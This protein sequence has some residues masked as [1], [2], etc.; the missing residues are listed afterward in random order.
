MKTQRLYLDQS[1]LIEFEANII[2]SFSYKANYAV[3][4]DQTAFYPTSGGQMHDT[5]TINGIEVTDVIEDD[6]EIVHLL[7]SSITT[8]PSRCSINWPRRF[9][10]MQQHTGFHII[11]QSFLRVT[12]AETLSSHLGENISTIDVNLQALNEQQIREVEELAHQVIFEDR[13]VKAYF[14]DPKKIDE[15]RIRKMPFNKD[16]IRLVEI[17]DFDLDPCGGTHVSSTGQVGLIK[18]NR[19]EKIRGYLRCEFYAGWRAIR[20]YQKK[21]AIGLQLSN[22]LS[23]GE[24]DFVTSIKKI[25]NENRFLIK[26]KKILTEQNIAYEAQELVR[27]AH[28][29]G[30]KVITKLFENRDLNEVR[31]L[32]KQITQLGDVWV[33]FGLNGE[34]AHLIFACP[35]GIDYN[36]NELV[37]QVAHLIEGRGGGRPNFV[38]I[39]GPQKSSIDEALQSA[40]VIV[41]NNVL[42]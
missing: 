6:G 30:K 37:D 18:I 20:D 33:L 31:N 39:G 42:I 13:R 14:I 7:A 2:R 25:Q 28:N 4:L 26:K 41:E 16:N 24:E 1:N 34:K 15:K 36:L 5:G 19:W 3:I 40:R 12:A 27:E 32:A 11:A 9:D 38:E 21:W 23:T 10:F 22:L 29:H 35:E 8:G 17:E